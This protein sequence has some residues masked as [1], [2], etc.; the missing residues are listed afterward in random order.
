MSE[1]EHTGASIVIRAE[2]PSDELAIRRVNELAF[3]QPDEADLVDRLR[4]S[5]CDAL[6]LVAEDGGEVVGHILFTPVVIEQG[7]R[8]LM[9][10]GLAPMAVLPDQQRRGIGSLLVK[11]GVQILRERQCP[12]VIVVGHPDYYPRFGFERAS[13]H[14]VGCQWREVPDEAFMILVL[15]PDALPGVSGVAR[16]RKEFDANS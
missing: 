5:G 10:M 16:Y 14:Q 2:R 7:Q 4:Q 15:E 3:A 6:S 8:S 11:R 1:A 12:F 13:R 9:G